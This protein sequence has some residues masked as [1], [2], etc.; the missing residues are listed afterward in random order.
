[1]PTLKSFPKPANSGM[2]ERSFS[3]DASTV[4][5]GPLTADGPVAFLPVAFFSATGC[6]FV[7]FETVEMSKGSSEGS[8]QSVTRI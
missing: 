7:S 4:G 5:I 8:C 2:D 3:Y 6:D 1:V